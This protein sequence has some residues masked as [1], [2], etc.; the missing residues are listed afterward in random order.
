MAGA[1]L[2]RTMLCTFTLSQPTLGSAMRS[3]AYCAIFEMLSTCRCTPS[4]HQGQQP[5]APW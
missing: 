1:D 2:A 5:Q 4:P 3:N